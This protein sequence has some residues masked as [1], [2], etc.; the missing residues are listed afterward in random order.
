MM[1]F[2]VASNSLKRVVQSRISSFSNTAYR[3]SLAST[4]SPQTL[5]SIQTLPEVSN[6]L[7]LNTDSALDG[8]DRAAQVFQQFN[9]NGEEY[10]AVKMLQAQGYMQ[11]FSY[12]KAMKVLDSLQKLDLTPDELFHSNLA[13]T[14]LLW[15]QGSWGKATVVANDL[16]DVAPQMEH[17]FSLRQGMALNALALCRLAAINTKDVDVVQLRKHAVDGDANSQLTGADDA[18]DLLKMAS[19]VLLKG[20]KDGKGGGSTSSDITNHRRLGLYCAASYCNQGGAELMT[21]LMKS[22]CVKRSVPIDSA[23]NAWRDA[24]N[25][26]DEIQQDESNLSEKESVFLKSTRARV[27][28]N[29]AWAILFSSSYID[30]TLDKGDKGVPV[31]EASL[32][33]ASEYAG[34]ALKINDDIENVDE[35]L[36]RI[37]CLVASCYARAGSA[38]TA[39]GLFQSAMDILKP[40]PNLSKT[41]DARSALL[42]YSKLCRNWE[43]RGADASKY[44]KLAL[45]MDDSLAEQWRGASSLYSG[46]RM[47]GCTDL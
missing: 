2:L 20:Y 38:V 40:S 12:P 47:F 23:M 10:R 14:R 7:S 8:L 32:K 34:L 26:L 29:M 30:L 35:N 24:L 19:K 6:A 16:C 41:I 31:K 25:V 9:P 5:A 1:K 17:N 27:Y 39:E 42:Y 43:K 44:E 33:L 11:L 22:A 28:C 4:I 45:E 13:T 46:F 18:Q 37:L 15:E 21:I 36:G 3:P